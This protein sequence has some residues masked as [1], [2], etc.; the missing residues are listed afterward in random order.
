M[1]KGALTNLTL[2][3][4]L[5]ESKMNKLR[6]ES[7]RITT[8]PYLVDANQGP[9]KMND[10]IIQTLAVNENYFNIPQET[11][12]VEPYILID[13]GETRKIQSVFISM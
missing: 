13:F 4:L 12:T 6:E 11:E 3:L 9:D 1:K 2:F 8:S 7:T 10:G 5:A